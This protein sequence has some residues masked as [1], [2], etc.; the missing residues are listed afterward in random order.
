M[1]LFTRVALGLLH[2]MEPQIL[3]ADCEQ[4]LQVVQVARTSIFDVQRRGRGKMPSVSGR[5]KNRL[6]RNSMAD[7]TVSEKLEAKEKDKSRGYEHSPMQSES[8]SQEHKKAI[9]MASQRFKVRSRDL[10][11][12]EMRFEIRKLEVVAYA[13]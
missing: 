10:E 11:S 5:N 9:V 4:I 2:A 3:S 8:G 7:A 6:K 12:L 13:S 1:P